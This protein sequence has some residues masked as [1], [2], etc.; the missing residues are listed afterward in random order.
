MPALADT[1]YVIEAAEEM[2]ENK[3]DNEENT[4]C[5]LIRMKS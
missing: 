4:T 1:V 5:I 3:I 2:F